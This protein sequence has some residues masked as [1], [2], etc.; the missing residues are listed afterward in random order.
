MIVINTK[1]NIP[2]NIKNKMP[3]IADDIIRQRHYNNGLITV[4]ID[5]EILIDVYNYLQG[6]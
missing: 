6:E 4:E 1:T 2:N 3:L 5:R